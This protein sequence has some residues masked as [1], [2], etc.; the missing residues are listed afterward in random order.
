MAAFALALTVCQVSAQSTVGCQRLS[1][2][3]FH[4]LSKSNEVIMVED[5]KTSTSSHI[6]YSAVR[7]A[8]YATYFMAQD[9]A[10]GIF[11]FTVKT[12]ISGLRN[13]S[14][15]MV[16]RAQF[17]PDKYV[18]MLMPAQS[19]ETPDVFCRT[20]ENLVKNMKPTHISMFEVA[21]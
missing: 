9:K 17:A 14:T 10:E 4:A 1:S 5:P 3:Q 21:A 19:P 15:K 7:K 16:I 13:G 2:V 20:N 6:V 18:T 11:R 12:A 8:E